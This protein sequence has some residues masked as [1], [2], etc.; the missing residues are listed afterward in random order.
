MKTFALTMLTTVVALNILV[1]YCAQNLADS[2]RVRMRTYGA[3][4]PAI[5]VMAIDSPPLFY[6]AG[7]VALAC[8][9]FG[10][11]RFPM[12]IQKQTIQTFF[13]LRRHGTDRGSPVFS[14]CIT[15][16]VHL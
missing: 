14:F 10:G 4:V 13:L 8:L 15:H 6:L 1:G 5:T 16:F 2:M 12:P 7:A 3:T 9:L 11:F